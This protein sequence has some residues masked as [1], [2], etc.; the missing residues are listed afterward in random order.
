MYIVGLARECREEVVAASSNVGQWS[1]RCSRRSSWGSPLGLLSGVEH[2]RL[3]ER[4]FRES[5]PGSDF[6]VLGLWPS[7]KSS[8]QCCW[9]MGR[10]GSKQSSKRA[11]PPLGHIRAVLLGIKVRWL[12]L[13][14]LLRRSPTRARSRFRCRPRVPAP[15]PAAR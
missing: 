3:G 4:V 6:C 12:G 10:C 14:Q 7:G 2:P 1:R 13:M 11:G 9:I 5:S 15:S 8:W